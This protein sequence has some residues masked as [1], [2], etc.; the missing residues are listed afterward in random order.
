MQT[1][2]LIEDNNDIRENMA[3][4]LELAGYQ[5]ITAEN[6][7]IG[8][9]QAKQK[10][11]DL[12]ICDIMMPVLDGYGVLH[13]L[14][15]DPELQSIPFIFLT[16]RTERTDIRK[17]MEM[18]ADDYITKPFEGTELL[19]A[20]ES[21]LKKTAM[22][23]ADFSNNLNG[24]NELIE[25][26][27]NK[28]YLSELKENRSI[29]YYKKKQ[30]IYTEGNHPSRLFYIQKGKVKCFKRNEEGKELILKL[31]NEGEFLGYMPLLEGITYKESAEALEETELAVIPRAEFEELVNSN[32]LVMKKFIHIL[33]VNIHENESHLLGLAFHSVR[34]KV[35]FT[36][37]TLYKKYHT[38]GDTD[39]TIDIS[40]DNLASLAGIAKESMIRT[41]GDFKE[42]KLI[43][44]QDNRI[45]ISNL[46]K[47]ETL[48]D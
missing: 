4:I 21:R 43:Q 2:L 10:N 35:A 24:V 12:I 18:G 15:R 34:K 48:I 8:I 45:F 32:P 36:L 31:Y 20:V 11:P 19:S 23:K 38:P 40:R 39:F 37:V 33:A 42:E 22:L 25:V 3:E 28:D 1:I 14:Q 46:H 41:L 5:V 47:L 16:A 27:A 6:G 29:N 13:L 30:L 44:I 9:E 7:K 26:A 17:G